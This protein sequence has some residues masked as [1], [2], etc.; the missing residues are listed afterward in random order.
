MSS[1]GIGM[2]QTPP[3]RLHADLPHARKLSLARFL[4]K[5][6]NRLLEIKILSANGT[7]KGENNVDERDSLQSETST[8]PRKRCKD[9]SREWPSFLNQP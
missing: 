7:K 3:R 2:R 4:Q 1:I 5:R 9:L 8:A 6:R